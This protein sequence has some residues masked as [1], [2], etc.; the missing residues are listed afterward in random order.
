MKKST[1]AAIIG[2]TFGGIN[3]GISI[4]LEMIIPKHWHITSFIIL[5]VTVPVFYYAYKKFVQNAD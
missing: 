2:G 4:L 3:G 5:L 1:K